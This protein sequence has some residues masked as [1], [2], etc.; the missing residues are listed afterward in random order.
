MSH[1]E[2]EIHNLTSDY[3]L[4]DLASALKDDVVFTECPEDGS[5]LEKG[6]QNCLKTTSDHIKCS[7]LFHT[8]CS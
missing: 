2:T 1:Q 5:T 3:I 6:M 7:K 8:Y 4:E